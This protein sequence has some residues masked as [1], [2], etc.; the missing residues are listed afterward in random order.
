MMKKVYVPL[1]VAMLAVLCSCTT[2]KKPTVPSTATPTTPT[3]TPSLPTPTTPPVSVTPTQP[4]PATPVARSYGSFAEWKADFIQRAEQQGHSRQQLERLLANAYYQQQIVSSDRNQSEFTKMPWS[5][6]DSAV[7]G[8]RV[9]QGKKNLS[10][11]YDVLNRIEAQTGVPA[12]IVTAIWG[13]ESSYGQA[14]GSAD[15]ASAL[16]T[17]A[18]EGRRREFAENQLLAMVSLLNS[19]DLSWNHLKGSWAGG[20]GHTQFIP[21]T[22]AQFGVDGNGDGRRNPWAAADAL[23][24]TGNYLG[25]SGWVRGISPYYEVNLPQGFDYSQVNTKKTLQQWRQLGVQYVSSTSP[26]ESVIAELWLPAGHQGP[27]LLLTPNFNVIKV[28]NNSSSYALG[29]STL[30]KA[31]V[32]LPTIQKSWPRHEQPL[33]KAQ[34]TVLQQRLTQAGFDTKGADGV[35]GT[36]TRLAFQRWQLANG[37]V[38]DG[39][40]SLS[41][42][43]QLLY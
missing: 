23:S 41:S 29:V 18:Y 14:T 40:I 5:Y 24:S 27:A 4:T 11:N 42:A 36:N 30:A 6:V 38:A 39:F 3:P 25:R 10:Q 34:A 43:R 12:S 17:L 1:T 26:D 32:D 15:L 31:I 9:G 22:W 21:T 19:G 7:S 35:I 37:Q 13:M 20:M 28:Y 33:S 8:S 16:A 2:N